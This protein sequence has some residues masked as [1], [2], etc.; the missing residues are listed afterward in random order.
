MHP[1]TAYKLQ[2]CELSVKIQIMAFDSFT[3]TLQSF[4][5]ESDISAI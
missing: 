4:L 5:I 1:E 3:P 2:S